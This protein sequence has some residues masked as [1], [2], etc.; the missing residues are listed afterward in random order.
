MI[1][2]LFSVVVFGCIAVAV[3][4]L[5]STFGGTL[6]QVALTKIISKKMSKLDWYV[7][8]M[9]I[10]FVFNFQITG[11]VNYAIGGPLLGLYFLGC[12]CP[13]VNAK[14]RMIIC[15][16]NNKIS[17]INDDE[18]TLR[19]HMIMS[20]SKRFREPFLVVLVEWQ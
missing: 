13:W 7:I 8:N 19:F 11:T 12:F 5:V 9:W 17:T 3:A 10:N 1:S 6:V 14:V 15:K 4:F 2:L 16:E 18:M 20:L